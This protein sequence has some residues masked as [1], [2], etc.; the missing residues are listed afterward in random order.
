MNVKIL[1]ILLMIF[2]ILL[3]SGC[4]EKQTLYVDRPVEVYIP[5]KCIIPET[6]CDFNKKTDTEVIF[7]MRTCIEDLRKSIKICQ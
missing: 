6:H 1:K 7:Y 3:F 2:A 5:T 4:S